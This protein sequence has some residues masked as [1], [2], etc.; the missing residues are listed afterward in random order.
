MQTLKV[1]KFSSD[2]VLPKKGRPGDAG[3]DISSNEDTVIPPN[4]SKL[5]NTGIGITVPDGTYGRLA[6]R[7][8]VSTKNIMINAGVIDKTY[9]GLI[10]CLM[11]NLSYD[12]EYTVKKG[13][14]ICQ[15]ILE[16]IVDECDI[17]EVDE[18]EET[19]RGADGFGSSGI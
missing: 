5:V 16:K 17:C 18:L 2:A 15:L 19:N 7:S 11:V 3:Y 4:S 8:G 1:K 14:R 9:T 13:D 12:K 6:P 10:K